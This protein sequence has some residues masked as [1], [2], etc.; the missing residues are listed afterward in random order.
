[1]LLGLLAL[2]VVI[3]FKGKDSDGIVHVPRDERV[4]FDRSDDT[5]EAE[6]RV[7]RDAPRVEDRTDRSTEIRV[8]RE[9]PTTDDKS[10]HSKESDKPGFPRWLGRFG[11]VFAPFPLQNPAFPTTSC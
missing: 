9:A 5:K 2:C 8:P 11:M 1:M 7:K 3:T 6:I 4:M 10:D